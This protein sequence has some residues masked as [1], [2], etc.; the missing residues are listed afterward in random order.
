[1]RVSEL[2]RHHVGVVRKLRVVQPMIVVKIVLV[3][4]HAQDGHP[5]RQ[6]RA[7]QQHVV[8]YIQ[9]EEGIRRLL[10]GHQRFLARVPNSLGRLLFER[11]TACTA[12]LLCASCA[13]ATPAQP[14]RSSE[15]SQKNGGRMRLHG[16]CALAI[17]IT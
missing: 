6:L 3:E 13:V 12:D 16:G 11:I 1:M 10:R 14:G 7:R 4:L 5:L 17:D 15:N 2:A 9:S 8:I